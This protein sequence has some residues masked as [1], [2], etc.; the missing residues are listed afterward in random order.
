MESS[1]APHR[2][3]ASKATA[4][5]LIKA[6]KARWVEPREQSVHVKGKGDYQTYWIVPRQRANSATDHSV[7]AYTLSEQ[8]LSQI[9]KP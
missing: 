1:G 6:K 3:H 5:L 8:D 2:I 9:E 4:E 7:S